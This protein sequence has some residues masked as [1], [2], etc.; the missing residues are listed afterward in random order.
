MYLNHH[1]PKRLEKIVMS[2]LYKL[3]K[4]W[5]HLNDTLKSN[6][7]NRVSE[8][9]MQPHGKRGTLVYQLDNN[10]DSYVNARRKCTTFYQVPFGFAKIHHWASLRSTMLPIYWLFPCKTREVSERQLLQN[11]R[12]LLLATY[13]VY[14]WQP[15]KWAYLHDDWIHRSCSPT[16]KS[17]SRS[18]VQIEWSQIAEISR[19][20]YLLS[21]LSLNIKDPPEY[22]SI[23]LCSC[24]FPKTILV[25][26]ACA[27]AAS[28]E[29]P[30][31]S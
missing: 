16:K 19:S 15:K 6:C 8:K 23:I 26:F 25:G 14:W 4:C 18:T 20:D 10:N 28:I 31:W 7:Y 11:S 27:Q 22:S 17:K 1:A 13:M 21:Q 12:L 2:I 9:V 24:H 29:A 30:S 5:S 3:L